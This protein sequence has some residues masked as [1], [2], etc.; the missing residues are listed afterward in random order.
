[1]QGPKTLD[2]GNFTTFIVL[3]GGGLRGICCVLMP[4]VVLGTR[5][6]INGSEGHLF[7]PNSAQSTPFNH[8]QKWCSTYSAGARV[9]FR[10][11]HLWVQKWLKNCLFPQLFLDDLGC[12]NKSFKAILSCIGPIL[13]H[14]R[15][16][17]PL[18]WAISR[19][20]LCWGAGLRG[21]SAMF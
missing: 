8:P 15:S 14:A 16:Q 21:G 1:M 11:G 6:M 7:Q 10:E 12:P 17:K 9:R 5:V 3:G 20:L 13:A 19:P 4:W 2:M 18:T